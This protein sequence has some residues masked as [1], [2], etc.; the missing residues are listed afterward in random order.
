MPFAF[1]V[2][3]CLATAIACGCAAEAGAVEPGSTGTTSGGGGMDQN[4]T[5]PVEQR[6]V[7]A[8]RPPEAV[9]N[10]RQGHRE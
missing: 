3:L 9:L 7:G 6:V 5:H 8:I 1:N 10:R 4:V 2:Q